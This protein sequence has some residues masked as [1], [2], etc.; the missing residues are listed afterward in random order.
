MEKKHIVGNVHLVT[1]TNR[2]PVPTLIFL[3]FFKSFIFEENVLTRVIAKRYLK[4]ST[5]FNMRNEDH[6]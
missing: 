1:E 5:L 6:S 3:Q 4:Y 2:Y